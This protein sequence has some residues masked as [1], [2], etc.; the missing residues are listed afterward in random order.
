MSNFNFECTTISVPIHVF[1][2]VVYWEDKK[3]E[4]Q[5][6]TWF[7]DKVEIS[8]PVVERLKYPFFPSPG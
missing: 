1:W 7:Q 6:S 5:P 2:P 3:K 4:Q 8:R